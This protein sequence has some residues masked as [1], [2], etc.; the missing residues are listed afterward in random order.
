MEKTVFKIP[1]N[2]LKN[3]KKEAHMRPYAFYAKTLSLGV[4]SAG[5]G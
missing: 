2:L 4:I 3:Q 1:Q 5:L